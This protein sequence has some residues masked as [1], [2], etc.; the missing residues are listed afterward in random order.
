MP[1]VRKARKTREERIDP[2][3]PYDSREIVQRIEAR[4]KKE[5]ISQA[6]LA[7]DM[8]IHKSGWTGRKKDSRSLTVDQV[9]AAARCLKAPFGWPFYTE[10]VAELLTR[11]AQGASPPPEPQPRPRSPRRRPQP[12]G[13]GDPKGAR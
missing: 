6:A 12:A 7:K 11:I 5:H 13:Q 1:P 9:S 3:P 8:G 4:R 2:A 10:E